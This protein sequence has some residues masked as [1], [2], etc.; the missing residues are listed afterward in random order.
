MRPVLEGLGFLRTLLFTLP[1]LYLATLVLGLAAEAAV[2]FDRQDQGQ[3]TLARLW[4]RVLLAASLIRVRVRGKE[5]LDWG[6]HYVF[7][8]NHVSYFDVPVLLATLPAGIQFMAKRSL[9]AIPFTGWYMRR[10]GHMP[11]EIDGNNVRANARQLLQAVR[12]IRQGHSIAVFPEGGRSLSGELQE[13]KAGI[14]LAALK[15]GAPVVPVA[16]TGT[17]AVLRR[18][19]WTIRPGQVELI[20][21]P[22]VE[23]E[24]M[25]KTQLG[26]LVAQVRERIEQHLEEASP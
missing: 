3:H 17:K 11:I 22:P 19:S 5:N 6:K 23:T 14:F 25:N 26:E 10:S 8:A 13:F 20:L 2:P 4:A 12:Q 18:N 16:I 15:V 7:V 1:L 24:G 9:F 21:D